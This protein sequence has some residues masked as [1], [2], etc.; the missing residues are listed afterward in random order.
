MKNRGTVLGKII[1]VI[2]CLVILC[3]VLI[4]ALFIY[5]HIYRSKI[6]KENKITSE[7]GIDEEVITEINGINQYLYIR[8][9]NKENPIILFIHGGPGS[10]I[11]PMIHTYQQ[12]LEDD[13]TVVNWEQRNAG[14]T[15]FLNEDR[16]DEIKSSLSVEQSVQDTYEIVSYLK[17]R[18]QKEII[19]MGHSWGST[20]GTIF[21]NKY[22]EMVKAYIGIGQ[23]ISIKDGEKLIVEETLKVIL[24]KDRDKY[25]EIVSDKNN[26]ELDSKNFNGENFAMH[27]AISGK[28]LME[29]TASETEFI[30]TI[31]LSPYYSLSE[32]RWFLM[33]NLELQKL[34]F[35]ELG[36]LDLRKDYTEFKVPMIYIS[37]DKDWITPYPM[38]E[39]YYDSIKAPYKKM[40]FI[41]NAGHTPMMDNPEVFSKEVINALKEIK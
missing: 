6:L 14:K 41:E 20:N 31:L 10:P 7:K 4:G 33:N 29:G 25:S 35:D 30:K 27:R 24:E 8:G 23:N 19:I 36:T 12:G 1:K 11:T 18:F 37:G 15:Y 39:E 3:I 5:R 22:P 32:A 16:A 9:Q 26:I 17:E 13:Y 34:L 21:V 40:V 38:V 2:V 28:Y